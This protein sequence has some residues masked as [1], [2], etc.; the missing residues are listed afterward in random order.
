MK[1]ISFQ[2]V[3]K[4][5]LRSILQPIKEFLYPPFCFLCDV[6]LQEN[7]SRVCTKCWSSFPRIEKGD[8][9][10]TDLKSKF[11]GDGAVDDCLS[12]YLFEKDGKLQEIIHH[13]KYSGMTAMGIRLGEEIGRVIREDLNFRKGDMVIPI[14]LHRLKQRERGYN[15]SEFICKGIASVTSI[16]LF[17]RLLTRAKYTQTQTQL[18]LNQRKENMESAFAVS[19]KSRKLLQGKKVILVDDVITTGSTINS[20]AQELRKFGV[21]SVLAASVAHAY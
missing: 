5:L 19:E 7:E 12:V 6:R 8:V 2:T 17:P 15:Q 11:S 4:P 13:L 18:D 16:P 20:C 9:I 3:I 14:P 10:D 1:V 21:E